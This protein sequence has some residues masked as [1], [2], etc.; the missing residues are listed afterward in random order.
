MYVGDRVDTDIEGARAVGMKTILVGSDSEL[1]DA[2]CST[3]YD[4]LSVL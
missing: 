2:S 3:V 1:A 4:I